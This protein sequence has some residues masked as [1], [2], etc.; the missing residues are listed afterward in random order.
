MGRFAF[1]ESQFG[2]LNIYTNKSTVTVY[3]LIDADYLLS[4]IVG[5]CMII[6]LAGVSIYFCALRSAF[7]S[8]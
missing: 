4:V 7:L 6:Y 1:D 3:H 2:R 8:G 5:N